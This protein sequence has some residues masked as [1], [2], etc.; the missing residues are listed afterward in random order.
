SSLVD[1][2]PL[3]AMDEL[4]VMMHPPHAD[5]AAGAVFGSRRTSTGT[6]VREASI[7]RTEAAMIAML[8]RFEHRLSSIDPE[9]CQ[10]PAQLVRA[11][12]GIWSD[13]ADLSDD[14]EERHARSEAPAHP[15]LA[16]YWN[17]RSSRIDT[18]QLVSNL[19][20]ASIPDAWF[21]GA[22]ALLLA[23]DRTVE[24]ELAW[25]AMADE[26]SATTLRDA[27]NELL[28]QA[29]RLLKGW[30]QRRGSEWDSATTRSP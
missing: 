15:L 5:P 29:R 3:L 6:L 11:L 26:V 18:G 8:S 10:S 22:D 7:D 13:A 4:V 23:I 21:S 19:E 30:R 1:I 27:L 20:M 17:E 24:L 2:E 28:D 14:G 12:A 9:N 25:L 16:A